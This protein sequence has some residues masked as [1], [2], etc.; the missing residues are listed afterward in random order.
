MNAVKLTYEEL[1]QRVD[2]LNQV[3]DAMRDGNV[4]SI[5]SGS[6]LLVLRDHELELLKEHQS[7][8]LRAILESVPTALAIVLPGGEI[9]VANK[10]F[11]DVSCISLGNCSSCSVSC[12]SRCTSLEQWTARLHVHGKF[13]EELK[14]HL[15]ESFEEQQ[16]PISV[17]I[18]FKTLAGIQHHWLITFQQFAGDIDGQAAVII[19]GTDMTEK[20]RLINQ[21]SD[22]KDQM[23]GFMAAAA[24][25]LKAPLITIAH[26]VTFARMGQADTLTAE[27]AECL[28]R[29]QSAEKNMMDLLTQISEVSRAGRD[30]EPH[31]LHSFRE[32]AQASLSQLEGT[33]S[34]RRAEVVIG[35]DLPELY[36]ARAPNS[37]RSSPT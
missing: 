3:L 26:N 5:I 29:I 10:A 30:T 11:C 18:T 1:S 9:Y 7:A 25:D 21:L 17:E 27:T 6:H 33:L 28:D 34:K 24:H 14:Q 13:A 2:E 37:S 8:E 16:Q 32:L 35:D 20:K 36:C 15:T 23:E 19:A 22:A 12:P 31:E 4:D